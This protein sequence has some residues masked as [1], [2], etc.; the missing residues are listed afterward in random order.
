MSTVK[1]K[2]QVH[3]RFN[4]HRNSSTSNFT[5]INTRDISISITNVEHECDCK[6]LSTSTSL[7][8]SSTLSRLNLPIMSKT[9]RCII[10]FS[11]PSTSCFSHSKTISRNL[12]NKSFIRSK[13]F[14]ISNSYTTVNRDQNALSVPSFCTS[15]NYHLTSK[16]FN[17]FVNFT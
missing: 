4:S 17:C 14:S 11:I 3:C 8:E 15:S 16:C 9:T 13:I 2:F 10:V 7:T 12:R 6:V 5:P 1:I